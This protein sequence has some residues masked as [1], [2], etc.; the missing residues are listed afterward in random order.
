MILVILAIWFGY[1][2][3][4]DTGRN[5]FLWA[6][7][8]AGAFIGAQL[9]VGIAGAVV[10][11]IMSQGLD[12]VDRDLGFAEGVINILAIIASF[13]ALW[14]VFRYLDKVPAKHDSAAEVDAGPPPPP[15]FD[16]VE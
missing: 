8:C 10:L 12:W 9:V 11:T 14:L 3:G 5:P 7:I 4:R 2:K 13:L 16:N 15:R 1:R 6:A